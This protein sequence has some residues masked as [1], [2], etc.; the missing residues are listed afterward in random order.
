MFGNQTLFNTAISY[1]TL[2]VCT[3][4]VDRDHAHFVKFLGNFHCTYS[5]NNG[6]ELSLAPHFLK[7]PPK[8]LECAR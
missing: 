8:Y 6:R 4:Q 5:S 3:P 7:F 2:L 1:M